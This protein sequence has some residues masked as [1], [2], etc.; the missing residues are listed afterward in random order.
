M[1]SFVLQSGQGVGKEFTIPQQSGRTGNAESERNYKGLKQA[2][3]LDLIRI[4]AKCFGLCYYGRLLRTCTI[5]H[6]T[7]GADG[8]GALVRSYAMLLSQ[9]RLHSW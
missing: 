6:G 9:S 7:G 5:P 8:E 3:S 4:E 2:P 1:T